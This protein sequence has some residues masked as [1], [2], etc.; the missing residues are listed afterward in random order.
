[1][2]HHLRAGVG[3]GV[4]AAAAEGTQQQDNCENR[5]LSRCQVVDARRLCTTT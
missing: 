4:G 2:H 5:S 3:V 1:V